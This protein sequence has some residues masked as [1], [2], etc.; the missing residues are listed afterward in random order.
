MR[1]PANGKVFSSDPK[2][3]YDHSRVPMKNKSSATEMHSATPRPIWRNP[4]VITWSAIVFVILSVNAGMIYLAIDSSPGLVVEDYYERG[5]NYEETV[6]TRQTRNRNLSL[7]IDV[8]PRIAIGQPATFRFTATKKTGE[9]IDADAVTLHA[10]RPSD[11]MGDFSISMTK[12]S[13]TTEAGAP[14]YL[15]KATFPL[16][17]VWDIVVTVKQGNTEHNVPTRITVMGD[18]ASRHAPFPIP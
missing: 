6:L 7:Q 13:T 12:T 3:Q 2:K 4:W 16:K 14:W 15:A 17:G 5:Q 9:P 11:I 1:S 10:Y 8:P 18:R